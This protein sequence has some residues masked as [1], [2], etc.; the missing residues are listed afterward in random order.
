[1]ENLADDLLF[2]LKLIK[3]SIPPTLFIHFVEGQLGELGLSHLS[4]KGS[5]LFYRV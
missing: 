2:G 4:L 1:M 3:L 5:T